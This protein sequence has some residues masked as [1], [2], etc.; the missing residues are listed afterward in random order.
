MVQLSKIK[1][2]PVMMLDGSEAGTI[3][4]PLLDKNGALTHL[5]LAPERWYEPPRVVSLAH[6]TGL[7]RELVLA[8]HPARY[9]YEDPGASSAAKAETQV[10]EKKAYSDEGRYLGEVCDLL[11]E[12]DGALAELILDSGIRLKRR[13]ILALGPIHVIVHTGEAAPHPVFDSLKGER[14][15]KADPAPT[16]PDPGPAESVKKQ[17]PSGADVIRQ[18]NEFLLGKALEKAV[19]EAGLSLPEGTVIEQKHIDEAR[20]KGLIVKLI[21][22]AGE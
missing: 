2:R 16:E 18:Q 22:S 17:D 6:L 15:T 19:D 20:E 7:E 5:V 13:S 11:F 21:M 9:L 3:T 4:M 12:N 1:G 10:L 14:E 8:T